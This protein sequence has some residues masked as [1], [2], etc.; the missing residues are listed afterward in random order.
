M[1]KDLQDPAK[2]I[3]EEKSLIDELEIERY[4]YVERK[5]WVPCHSKYKHRC[6][7]EQCIEFGFEPHR[8]A[9]VPLE[10]PQWSMVCWVPRPPRLQQ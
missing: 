8:P 2:E 9:A 5:R 7:R 10:R 6:D 3:E 1:G 4:L